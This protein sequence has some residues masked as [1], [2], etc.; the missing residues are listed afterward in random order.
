M[1]GNISA[2]IEYIID[3]KYGTI[4]YTVVVITLDIKLT[5]YYTRYHSIKMYAHVTFFAQLTYV[6]VLHWIVEL[7][8]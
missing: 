2:L 5:V 4:H 6:N 3:W 8:Y 7:Y 1:N